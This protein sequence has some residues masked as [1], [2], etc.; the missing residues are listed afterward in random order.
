MSD[1]KVFNIGE[2]TV[3]TEN[4]LDILAQDIDR[5]IRTRNNTE[6][7]K[8][9]LANTYNQIFNRIK[10]GDGSIYIDTIDGKDVLV[11]TTGQLT[12]SGESFDPVG[13]MAGYLMPRIKKAK[14]YT[15]KSKEEKFSFKEFGKAILND[16]TGNDL[17]N[18]NNFIYLDPLSEE[19]NTRSQ[20]ERIRAFKTSFDKVYNEYIQKYPNANIDK[21]RIDSILADGVLGEN[22]F[23]D[24]QKYTGINNISKLFSTSKYYPTDQITQTQETEETE[25]S[26]SSQKTIGFLNW[27][28]DE[29]PYS[30]S[31]SEYSIDLKSGLT[32]NQ[33][34]ASL[35]MQGLNNT[36]ST[37]ELFNGINNLIN[38]DNLQ[39][40]S[41]SMLAIL[42]VL[43][44]NN[45]LI[46]IGDDKYIVPNIKTDNI[47][48]S[49]IFD[50]KNARFYEVNNHDLPYYQQK[51]INEY[52]QNILASQG[53]SN[54]ELY[55]KYSQYFVS[56]NKK[57]GI[58]KA[59]QGIQ[60]PEWY[61][62]LFQ[63]K[64]LSGWDSSKRSDNW[65][66]G[67]THG[68]A[69]SLEDRYSLNK[70][71]T[72]GNTIGSDIQNYLNSNSNGYSTIEDFITAYNNDAKTLRD[73]WS[74]ERSYNETGIS[75]FNDL[76]K[77]MFKSRS[78]GNNPYSITWQEDQKDILG[79]TTWLRSMDSYEKEFDQLSDEEKKAR[80]H[81][82]KIGDKEYQVYKKTN[83]DIGL[84]QPNASTP[85]QTGTQ[86]GQTST[87]VTP[88]G[89]NSTQTE[90]IESEV[91]SMYEAPKFEEEKTNYWPE[92][93]QMTGATGRIGA[94]LAANN[95]IKDDL[96]Q[97]IQLVLKDPYELYYPVTGDFATMQHYNNQAADLRHRAELL[98]TTDPE[99]NAA[100]WANANK[101]ANELETKGFLADNA[102]IRRTMGEALKR[103]EQGIVLR[104]QIANYNRQQIADF[105]SKL[106]ELEASYKQK[107]WAGLDKFL[108]DTETITASILDKERIKAEE[109]RQLRN[110]ASYESAK[111]L[112]DSDYKNWTEA[113]KNAYTLDGD[114]WNDLQKDRYNKFLQMARDLYAARLTQANYDKSGLVYKNPLLDYK[115]LDWDSYF[116]TGLFKKGKTK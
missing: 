70:A 49:F 41:D 21:S 67:G 60:I 43:R 88:T 90:P 50:S 73:F 19:T 81:T 11:D 52:Q 44:N 104:N 46:S 62:K 48:T 107:N 27:L 45:K 28:N 38:E 115:D 12:N 111:A 106:N 69:G 86:T 18:L 47:G 68:N 22:E 26:N 66:S 74:T 83:G 84:V 15:S 93:T 105:N 29:H 6:E 114:N 33:N 96:K 1:V 110:N 42:E 98:Y 95:D 64:A 72:E 103:R 63:Y 9:A 79:S 109:Q 4:V 31:T 32:Y 65:T 13:I 36:W 108:K 34:Q 17:N 89:N 56:Y 85:T 23:F 55:N 54:P 97:A 16:L 2:N 7:E 99:K 40:K 58:L 101:A 14:S 71:Y 113:A 10:S 112:A 100:I 77:K 92:I 76:F 35:L 78:E 116:N 25:N 57:G 102:E 75:S 82:I 8:A 24:L 30:V 20:A 39:N 3:K 51:Y 53:I 37:E 91:A 94:Q 5:F 80:T 59:Q 61:D 87:Q